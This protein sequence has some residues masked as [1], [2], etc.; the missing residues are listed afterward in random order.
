MIGRCI[1]F[2]NDRV[3]SSLNVRAS[4][5]ARGA[6]CNLPSDVHT[7]EASLRCVD[8][9]TARADGTIRG[10]H[11]S[12]RNVHESTLVPFTACCGDFQPRVRVRPG[13][14]PAITD[15]LQLRVHF[16]G[17]LQDACIW[18]SSSVT[19]ARTR[20]HFRIDSCSILRFLQSFQQVQD[21]LEI[22]RP[23]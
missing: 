2:S 7:A 21:L 3:S 23:E 5:L 15:G 8:F 20:V 19:V 9:V 12:T 11:E 16:L 22:A 18:A 10:V 6:G 13:T 4:S 1:Q 17:S 14:A